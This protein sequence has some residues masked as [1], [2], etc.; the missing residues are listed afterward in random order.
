MQKLWWNHREWSKHTFKCYVNVIYWS[1]EQG[2]RLALQRLRDH[3]CLQLTA[4]ALCHIAIIS[5]DSAYVSAL[6]LPLQRTLASGQ[7]SCIH[8]HP[9]TVSALE[10]GWSSAFEKCLEHQPP[11]LEG[12]LPA[13]STAESA[14]PGVKRFP[15]FFMGVLQAWMFTPSVFLGKHVV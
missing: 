9:D 15:A 11:H 10:Q 12:A 5:I 8:F 4:P 3:W 2:W 13:A 1:A 14:A 6:L 7:G